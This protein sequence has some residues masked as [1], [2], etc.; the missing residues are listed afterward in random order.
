MTFLPTTNRFK[1]HTLLT[2]GPIMHIIKLDIFVM[3]TVAAQIKCD[4][5][6]SA[7]GLVLLISVFYNYCILFHGFRKIFLYYYA[8]VILF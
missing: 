6:K 4:V 2:C 5:I 1:S 3:Q 7:A 8:F